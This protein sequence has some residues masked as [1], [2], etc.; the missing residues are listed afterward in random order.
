MKAR[1]ININNVV[2]VTVLEP[3][4]SDGL[5]DYDSHE[6]ILNI[7]TNATENGMPYIIKEEFKS[8]LFCIYATIPWAT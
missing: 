6:W 7:V 3:Y 1:F 8:K 5:C 4:K 2:E